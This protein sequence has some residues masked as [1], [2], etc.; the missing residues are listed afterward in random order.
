LWRD[1][2]P[3]LR[4]AAGVVEQAIRDCR[5]GD[6]SA[7]ADVSAGGCDWLLSQLTP[8]ETSYQAARKRLREIA[9]VALELDTP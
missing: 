2:V 4:L 3:Y 9:G 5:R 1:S 8:D 7:R 6:Q